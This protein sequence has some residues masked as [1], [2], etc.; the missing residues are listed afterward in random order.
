MFSFTDNT[1]ARKLVSVP[2]DYDESLAYY[3]AMLEKCSYNA[4]ALRHSR[5]LLVLYLGGQQSGKLSGLGIM[6]DVRRNMA[7]SM[8]RIRLLKCVD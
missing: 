3:R 1:L 5:R 6:S 8:R 7:L 4:R 2:L